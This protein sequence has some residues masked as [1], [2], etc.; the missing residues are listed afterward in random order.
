MDILSASS[1]LRSRANRMWQRDRRLAHQLQLLRED[2][3][4]AII[5]PVPCTRMKISR[6]WERAYHDLWNS[7]FSSNY[8]YPNSIFRRR[9]HMHYS[10]IILPHS[11]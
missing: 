8:M 7:C 10:L 3:S 4:R 6:D 1:L 11:S 5:P 2:F 9:F